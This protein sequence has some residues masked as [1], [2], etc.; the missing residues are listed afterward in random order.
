MSLDR[1]KSVLIEK[2]KLRSR[3]LPNIVMSEIVPQGGSAQLGRHFGQYHLARGQEVEP[4]QAQ[5][6]YSATLSVS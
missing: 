5:Y 1:W 3:G 2:P 6:C 4:G